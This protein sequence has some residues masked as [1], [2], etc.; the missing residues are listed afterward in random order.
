MRF[1]LVISI[2]LLLFSCGKKGEEKQ[3]TVVSKESETV[4]EDSS[5]S[6][7]ISENQF[8]D[9]LNK[10][11]ERE[12]INLAEK[13]GSYYK[14]INR[15]WKTDDFSFSVYELAYDEKKGVLVGMNKE[16]TEIKAIH[17]KT[18][19]TVWKT[20]LNLTKPEK[21]DK[22]EETKDR[23][24]YITLEEQDPGRDNSEP[25]FA[26]DGKGV[27]VAAV[28]RR[29]EKKKWQYE[30]T[31]FGV[32]INN[33]KIK[34]RKKLS[35]DDKKNPFPWQKSG[36]SLWS[37]DGVFYLGEPEKGPLYI[38]DQTNGEWYDIRFPK[39][40]NVT[41]SFA[42]TD[43]KHT[44]FFKSGPSVGFVLEALDREDG[45]KL[46]EKTYSCRLRPAFFMGREISNHSFLCSKQ[47]T[48]GNT[49]KHIDSYIQFD[50]KNG[51]VLKETIIEERTPNPN[52]TKDMIYMKL[53]PDKKSIYIRSLYYLA[54]LDSKTKEMAWKIP[55]NV[56]KVN[57]IFVDS[58]FLKHEWVLG[59][60]EAYDDYLMID[61]TNGK[62]AWNK[63]EVAT[64]EKQSPGMPANAQ[65]IENWI[66]SYGDQ[67]IR[68]FN[69]NDGEEI[70][71]YE[72]TDKIESIYLS[73]G[74]FYLETHGVRRGFKLPNFEIW[75]Y[76]RTKNETLLNNGW[77]KGLG[78]DLVLYNEDDKQIY[79]LEPL[80]AT[81]KYTLPKESITKATVITPMNHYHALS[82]S[83]DG[84]NLYFSAIERNSEATFKMNLESRLVE[85]L[86]KEERF[87]W[88]V[89]QNSLKK[90]EQTVSLTNQPI[91]TIE[92]Y[93]F[94]RDRKKIFYVERE[95]SVKKDEVVFKN[96]S[97]NVYDIENSK[98][99]TFFRLKNAVAEIR[100]GMIFEF[101]VRYG[102]FGPNEVITF[103]I[104]N[105]HGHKGLYT[106]RYDVSKPLEIDIKLDEEDEI[107]EYP[108]PTK[109]NL[110]PTE[111]L[112]FLERG[113][114][115]S[116]YDSIKWSSKP[117]L[118]LG[119]F[120]GLKYY[121]PEKNG[122]KENLFEHLITTYEW[123]P[124][125]EF[126][127][128]NSGGNLYLFYPAT[129]E[130]KQLSYF[131]PKREPKNLDDTQL[132][133]KYRVRSLAISPDG[134]TAAIS[135]KLDDEALRKIVLIDLT[136]YL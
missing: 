5:E 31:Y 123:H 83:D 74:V 120:F 71:K 20:K 104:E 128:M 55:L 29:D 9:T 46:W 116:F 39:D 135:L 54:K 130:I 63:R 96:I 79:Q 136:P 108:F 98:K 95:S 114:N 43:E 106:M 8:L 41:Y 40:E 61:A 85:K 48:D 14:P 107:S 28:N 7:E 36:W 37:Q 101:I 70:W 13:D 52:I 62:T 65:I 2:L 26:Y 73:N 45:S 87:G 17:I 97:F 49:F 124:N 47:P 118:A 92:F 76:D 90:G 100:N 44:Y 21:L 16:Q 132:G 94:D 50:A 88:E 133:N 60:D 134:K 27:V 91:G 122:Y 15:R 23:V 34:W 126:M 121:T 82:F 99:H 75:S 10:K 78:S 59:G 58:L 69:V 38:I 111:G 1:L 125:G 24:E 86:G 33:G 129:K 105:M 3:K 115:E 6:N 51:E 112:E 80:S 68:V 22:K 113:Y 12:S 53:S 119:E 89:T 66:V 109:L 32:D 57:A 30:L 93:K 72:T 131:L 4:K 67:V 11:V 81:R 25:S 18:G 110:P 42:G 19:K 117:Y 35:P 64:K 84:K 56:T 77:L 102:S 103:S 127:L